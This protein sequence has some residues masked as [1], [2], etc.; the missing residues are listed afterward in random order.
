[1]DGPTGIA[2]AGAQ[3]LSLGFVG[4]GRERSAQT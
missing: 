4:V 1:M 3:A 2:R